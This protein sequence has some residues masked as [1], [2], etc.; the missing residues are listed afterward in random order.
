MKRLNIIIFVFTTSIGW[1][2]ANWIAIAINWIMPKFFII[3]PNFL[4]V[5][6]F[7]KPTITSE[8][9]GYIIYATTALIMYILS[10][11]LQSLY[12]KDW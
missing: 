12:Q 1:F 6:F 9:L 4:Y 2:L 10:N 8:F 11:Y 5:L 7:K 3:D